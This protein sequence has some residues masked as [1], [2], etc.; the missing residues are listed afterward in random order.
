MSLPAAEKPK[1]LV[2]MEFRPGELP[3]AESVEAVSSYEPN[4]LRDDEGRF[5]L[6]GWPAPLKRYQSES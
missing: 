2:D 4:E 6:W 5:G 1:R 3:P